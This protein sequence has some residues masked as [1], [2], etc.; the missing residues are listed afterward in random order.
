[1]TFFVDPQ[2]TIH[3]IAKGLTGSDISMKVINSFSYI[4]C[5][6]LNFEVCLLYQSKMI[7][8]PV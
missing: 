8:G 5:N 4:T 1:M 3:E 7:S 6:F 2:K